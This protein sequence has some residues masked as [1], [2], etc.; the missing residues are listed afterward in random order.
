LSGYILIIGLR[1]II[2]PQ[3][4]TSHFLRSKSRCVLWDKNAL[5]RIE[6]IVTSREGIVTPIIL[7]ILYT[8]NH[9]LYKRLAVTTQLD[10]DDLR[11]N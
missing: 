5:Y 7:Y 3:Q 9:I 4:Y 6:K 8:V 2:H 1:P 10:P 11:G